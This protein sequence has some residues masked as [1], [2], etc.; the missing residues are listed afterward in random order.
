L[1]PN[2]I[3]KLFNL[4]LMDP[5]SDSLLDILNFSCS[6]FVDKCLHLSLV[7]LA[8]VID[9]NRV[10][11][12]IELFLRKSVGLTK[13]S[14]VSNNEAAHFGDRKLARVILIISSPDFINKLRLLD[15]MSNSFLNI[16]NFCSSDFT[17]K[18]FHLG[19]IDLTVLIDVNGVE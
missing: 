13:L 12:S 5:F 15:F 18:C 4:L 11:E 7:N 16:L 2:H 1:S 8:I 6:D 19:F 14:E 3:N 10:E 9:V 17:N